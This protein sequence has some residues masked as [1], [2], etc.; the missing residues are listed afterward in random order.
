MR[1]ILMQDPEEWT[2]SDV[3]EIVAARL[4]E[5]QRLDYKR[6]LHLNSRRERA[7]VAKD[8]S[9]F[10]NAQGGWLLFGVEEDDSEEP[11]PV[12]I[13]SMALDGQQSKLESILD[14]T[15]HP[16]PTYRASTIEEEPG[17][18]LIVV[19]V[20]PH[21]GLP[22][23]V[24]GFGQYRYFRRSGLRTRPM[25][26]SE[27]ATAHAAATGREERALQKLAELPLLARIARPRVADAAR[28]AAATGVP[29]ARWVPLSTVVVA[30]LDGP[31]ELI[32]PEW[33]EP[34][35]F[36]EKFE[37]RRGSGGECSV[38]RVHQY[39]ISALG[40][41]EVVQDDQDPLLIRHRVSI[42]RLGVVE[43]A[44]RYRGDK[45]PST[46]LANDVHNVLDYASHVLETV[47]YAGRVGVWV[48]IENADEATLAI[49]HSIDADPRTPAVEW[50]GHYCEASLDE[51]RTD[52]SSV[53]RL[54]M[55]RIWQGFG[56]RRCL[57]FDPDGGWRS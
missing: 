15:L 53:V 22:V 19:K 38:R 8:V 14:S 12:A 50:V 39:E 28:I 30:A 23:M 41:E 51:L 45:V 33:M 18:G 10:A 42:Y 25:T 47:G 24:Q 34:N 55:D 31:D 57:L 35:G 56:L 46:S 11:L 48:R 3:E 20:E 26:A 5:G 17:R 7:E 2:L 21:A 32:G 40:L 6:E 4:P 36:A 49:A 37:R 16:I 54:T 13:R 43:W 29:P 44:H 9:G 1:H 27:V 52:P